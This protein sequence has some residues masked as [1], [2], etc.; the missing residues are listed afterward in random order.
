MPLKRKVI[1]DKIKCTNY[2]IKEG[3]K[4]MEERK[5][6]KISLSTILLFVAILVIIVV[7]FCIYIE[8]KDSNKQI[9]NLEVNVVTDEAL[10]LTKTYTN[11]STKLTFDDEKFNIYLDE[12]FSLNGSCEMVD[13]TILVCNILEYTFNGPD[14]ITKHDIDKN[15]TW[16]ISFDIKNEKTIEVNEIN[17][18]ER[19]S[20]IIITIFNLIEIGDDFLLVD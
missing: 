6:V 7:T 1:S 18:P 3:G 19:N 20:E 15:E 13:N 16:T 10:Y 4:S 17:L 11:E 2:S 14:G 5:T 8:K 12:K 9:E